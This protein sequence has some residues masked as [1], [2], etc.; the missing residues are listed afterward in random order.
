MVV[1]KGTLLLALSLAVS[2]L[3]T[4]PIDDCPYHPPPPPVQWPYTFNASWNEQTT[5]TGVTKY[6]GGNTLYNWN[7]GVNPSMVWARWDGWADPYCNN[8][9]PLPYDSQCQHI[10]SGGKRYLYYPI[11]GQCCYCCNDAQ[12]C[13]VP[14]YNFLGS[15][16][17]LGEDV[18]YGIDVKMWE[19]GDYVYYETTETE[20][21]DRDWVATIATNDT[22]TYVWSFS[23]T[24]ND[25]S[26]LEVPGL[27]S[28][29]AACPAGPCLARRTL[30]TAGPPILFN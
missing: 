22:Y 14:A 13:G 8:S 16:R 23:R 17:Y 4:V 28:V 12:G 15:S 30:G 7:N 11:L 3:T 19:L 5:F 1:M 24:I 26:A 25:P 10:V 29:A 6:S 21:A 20:P 2:S 27:C 9:L 18:Y